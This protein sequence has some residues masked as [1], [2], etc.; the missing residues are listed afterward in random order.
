[1]WKD[2]LSSFPMKEFIGLRPRC[3]VNLI[4]DGITGKIAKGVEKCVTKKGLKFNAYKN[5]LINN[6]KIMRSQQTLKT[7]CKDILL[8]IKDIL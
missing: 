2:E 1:M 3:Y 5:C 4:D 6:E 8:N 7:S